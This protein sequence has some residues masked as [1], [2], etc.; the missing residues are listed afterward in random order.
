MYPRW[1]AVGTI[2]VPFSYIGRSIYR[3]R[4][5]ADPLVRGGQLSG[6]AGGLRTIL[7]GGERAGENKPWTVLYVLL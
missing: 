7:R 6:I 2:A 3:R 4:T 1:F 5:A